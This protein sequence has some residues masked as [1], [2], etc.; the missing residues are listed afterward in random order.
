[1]NTNSRNIRV[2]FLPGCKVSNPE[3]NWKR[4]RNFR[5]VLGN[6][7][8]KAHDLMHLLYWKINQRICLCQFTVSREGNVTN[9]YLAILASEIRRRG[10]RIVKGM[11][12]YLPAM[13]ES[14]P[15]AYATMCL[16]TFQTIGSTK[17][18]TAKTSQFIIKKQCYKFVSRREEPFPLRGTVRNSTRNR[19]K[20]HVEK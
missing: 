19:S 6:L 2:S 17:T 5:K 15:V 7:C 16:Y 4:Y 12:K 9:A 10:T 8:D 14:R 13:S 3:K 18:V 11:P 1:M 20:L